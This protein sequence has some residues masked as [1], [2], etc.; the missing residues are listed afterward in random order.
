[1]RVADTFARDHL[2]PKSEWPE[3]VFDRPEYQYPQQVNC[4]TELLDR[5]VDA[6]NGARPALTA[7]ID[8]RAVSCTYLQ[9]Q[10]SQSHR[11][12]VIE[13]LKL[14]PAIACCCAHRNAMLAAAGSRSSRPD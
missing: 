1:M 11:T 4:V 2:P 8:G 3:F 13:D 9:L 6:G 5:Q 12:R 14:A 10:R 7:L